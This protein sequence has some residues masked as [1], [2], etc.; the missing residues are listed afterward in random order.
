MN[1]RF[2]F[3]LVC[4]G[5]LLLFATEDSSGAL[6]NITFDNSV[7]TTDIGTITQVSNT[8][9]GTTLP[10]S[11]VEYSVSGLSIDSIG[12]LDDSFS[13]IF[14]L[15]ATGSAASGVAAIGIGS[16]GGDWG[17]NSNGTAGGEAA[18]SFDAVGESLTLSFTSASVSLGTV[19][20]DLPFVSFLGF[21]G[22]DLTSFGA[23]TYDLQG[24][25]VDGTGLSTD[26]NSFSPTQSFT[27]AHRSGSFSISDIRA[28]FDVSAATAVPEPSSLAMV[29]LSG[30][31]FVSFRRR[32]RI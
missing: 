19:S 22:F 20:T 23:D 2:L 31:G 5:S 8:T 14:S 17:I 21:T 11:S 15:S 30:I 29:C 26:P 9:G 3:A 24:T 32:H 12:A 27:I 28:R 16:S 7:R 13:F 1:R 25:T 10:P 6:V 4:C 18:G